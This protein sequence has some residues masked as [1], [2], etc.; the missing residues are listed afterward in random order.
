MDRGEGQKW[1]RA[2]GNL[3]STPQQIN[4][5]EGKTPTINL[6]FDHIIPPIQAPKDS[7]YVKH[8]RMRSKLLSEFWGRDMYVGAHV[9]LP[10]GWADHPD[11]HY[12]LAIFH[13]HF[14]SDFGGWR[15]TP[16]DPNL[17][18]DYSE[19]FG[20]NGYNKI[21]QQEAYDLSLIHI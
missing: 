7:E 10:E 11:I 2:P 1:N 21:L 5:K 6:N 17:Q 9:L 14:P 12:P 4:I 16:P 15:T 13:G 18:P 8:I 3:Y 19:R 20:V